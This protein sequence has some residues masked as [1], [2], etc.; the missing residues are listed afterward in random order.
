VPGAQHLP[1]GPPLLL[2]AQWRV[3]KEFNVDCLRPY[4]RRPSHLGGKTGPPAPV[5]GAD[6][7][8]EHKVAELLKF[9]MRYGRPHVLVQWTGRDAL[10]NTWEPLQN[11]TNCEDAITAFER[12]TGRTLPR[13]ASRPPL[14]AGT[15]SPHPLL[16]PAGFTVDA[17]PPPDL[18]A[19]LVGR[20]LLYWWLDDGWQCGTV[21]RLCPRPAFSHVVAYTRHTSALRGTADSLLDSASYSARCLLLSPAP[22]TGVRGRAGPHP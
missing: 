9:K 15:A 20:Q 4:V 16:P 22:A 12:A 7:A 5:F 19:A 18:G 1:P 13:P 3:F 2:A 11:L 6:G 14:A 17:A 10:G 8:P 21:A